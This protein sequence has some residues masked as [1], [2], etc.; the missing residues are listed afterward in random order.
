MQFFSL[1][2]LLIERVKA[3]KIDFNNKV[4]KITNNLTFNEALL[5][6]Q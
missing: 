2:I 4:I 3:F 6:Q 1:S 5:C